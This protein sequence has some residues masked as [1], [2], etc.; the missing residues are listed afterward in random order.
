MI[1]HFINRATVS[2]IALAMRGVDFGRLQANAPNCLY[3]MVMSGIPM[4]WSPAYTKRG[5]RPGLVRWS[6]MI[7]HRLDMWQSLSR[8]TRTAV[9]RYRNLHTTARSLHTRRTRRCIFTLAYVMLTVK[10]PPAVTT[11]FRDLSTT[12]QARYLHSPFQR[13]S[14]PF[15]CIF[16]SERGLSDNV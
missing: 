3:T 5:K 12:M 14:H 6:A 2:L 8:S 7:M 11:F 1:I 4:L 13:T 15:G 9:L 16:N 10:S